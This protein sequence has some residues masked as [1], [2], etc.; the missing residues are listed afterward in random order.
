[1]IDPY[2][3]LAMPFNFILS[4]NLSFVKLKYPVFIM[5]MLLNTILV[6]YVIPCILSPDF[7][8]S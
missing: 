2:V 7:L 8:T 6:M 3:I 4:G 1:M 5:A